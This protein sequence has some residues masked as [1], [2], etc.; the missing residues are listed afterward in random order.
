MLR[1]LYS[2]KGKDQESYTFIY[3]FA[4]KI[5]TKSGFQIV[6]FLCVVNKFIY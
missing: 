3:N 2:S 4:H 1:P 6:S 5:I